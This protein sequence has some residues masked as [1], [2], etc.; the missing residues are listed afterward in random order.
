VTRD[1]AP[2]EKVTGGGWILG[3][4]LDDAKKTFGFNAMRDKDGLLKGKLE[5]VDH[6]TK[7]NVH[8]D[9]DSLVINGNEAMFGGNCRVNGEDGY[10]LW[11]HVVDWGE[12]GRDDYFGISVRGPG[13]FFYWASGTLGPNPGGGGGNIQIH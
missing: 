5:Y 9:I 1:D 2:V 10:T 13:D 12:P 11:V 4:C 3:I 8:G 7:M 6:G